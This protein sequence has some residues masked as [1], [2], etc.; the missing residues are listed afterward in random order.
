M[1]KYLTQVLNVFFVIIVNLVLVSVCF[2]QEAGSEPSL[3]QA[4]S[5]MLPM[6]IMLF[7]VWY[8]LVI[9]P[10][11]S[12]MKEHSNLISGLKKGDMVVTTG[13]II[14]KVAGKESDHVLLEISNNTRV[15]FEP[16]HILKS[17]TTDIKKSD[18]AA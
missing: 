12:R 1:K 4:L 17:F 11:Q 5:R 6:F 10:Q 8:F 13:G 14:A 9:K 15:K 16:S 7:F 18:K 2:A 3:V